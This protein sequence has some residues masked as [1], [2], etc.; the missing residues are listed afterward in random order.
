MFFFCGRSLR[1]IQGDCYIASVATKDEPVFGL[2]RKLDD[3]SRGKAKHSLGFVEEEFRKIGLV[4]TAETAKELR[5]ALDKPTAMQN[6]QW[7]I[8]EVASL[9]R[10]ADKE[11]HGKSFL[12]IPVE[13]ARFWPT[14]NQPNPFGDLVASK[15]PSVSFDAGN[16]G[17]CLATMTP[18]AAVFHLMRVLE[19]GLAA[20]GKV[21]NVSLAHTNWEP[22]IREIE[23]KIREMHKDPAWKVLPDCK[24]QQEFYAQAASHFAIL[25][26]AW[27]NHTMHVRGKYTEDEGERI[28]DTVKAFMQKLAERLQE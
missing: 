24:E 8:N 3:L 10:L 15:F 21:F 16:A 18:T 9:E 17:V 28:F 22:A 4:I 7:L 6:F 12:Y 23:S 13:R 20:L 19:I 14:M 2:V 27:R 25:K 5:E 26:D 11:L 1:E